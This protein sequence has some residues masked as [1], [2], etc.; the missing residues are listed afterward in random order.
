MP[1]VRKVAVMTSGGD[2]NKLE[3]V[4]RLILYALIGVFIVVL[5]KTIVFV[6]KS[7]V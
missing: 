2:A 6:I 5:A 7:I 1:E 3:E 4:K